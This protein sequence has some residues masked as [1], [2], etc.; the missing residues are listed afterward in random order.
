MKRRLIV[1]Y[2]RFGAT[3]WSNFRGS[4]RHLKIASIGYS[5]TLVTNG[6][7]TQH[8][9]PEEQRSHLICGR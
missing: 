9:M 6:Q 7:S 3:Y 4:A 2:R 8:N 1:S 5:E